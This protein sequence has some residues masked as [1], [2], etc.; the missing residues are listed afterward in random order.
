MKKK[1]NRQQDGFEVFI[2]VIFLVPELGLK[3]MA[4]QPESCGNQT[5]KSGIKLLRKAL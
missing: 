3:L 5:P 1:K 4:S 2:T